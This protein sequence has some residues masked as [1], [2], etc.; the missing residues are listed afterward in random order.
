M[1]YL[2]VSVLNTIINTGNSKIYTFI[3]EIN[4][5]THLLIESI[6]LTIHP[7]PIN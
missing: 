4:G 3:F 2:D 5:D 6:G 1:K 7:F